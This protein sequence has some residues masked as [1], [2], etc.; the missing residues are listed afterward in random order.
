VNVERYLPVLVVHASAHE[1][2][3]K[4]LGEDGMR[5]RHG[6]AASARRVLM[7]GAGILAIAGVTSPSARAIDFEYG[8]V[9]GSLINTVS[10]GMQMRVSDRDRRLMGAAN[11]GDPVL[12]MTQNAEDNN[13]HFNQGDIVSAP[14]KLTTELNLAWRN[15]G[16][17]GRGTAFYDPIYDN[18]KLADFGDPTSPTFGR[19]TKAARDKAARGAEVQDLFV[20][21]EF[22]IGTQPLNVRIGQQTLNWGEALFTQNAISIINPLDLQKLVVP[23][24]ELRDGLI[25]VPMA[26]ASYEIVE[27]LAIEGFY[28]WEFKKLRLSPTGT[29]FGGSDVVEESNDGI[30]GVSNGAD[31]GAAGQN[32]PCAR[33]LANR[34]PGDSGNWGVKLNVFSEALN[35][36]EFGLYFVHYTSRF[37]SLGYVVTSGLPGAADVNGNPLPFN[38]NQ[39]YFTNVYSRT[40][41]AKGIKMVGLSFNT[42]WDEPG[43]AFNGELSYKMDE[44]GAIYGTTTYLQ[45]LCQGLGIASNGCGNQVGNYFGLPGAN[46]PGEI[47]GYIPL[48]AYHANLR[49][50]KI[51]FQ[52][53]PIVEATGAESLTLVNE[54]SLVYITNLPDSGRLSLSPQI[55][56][57]CGA[58]ASFGVEGSCR[59]RAATK[60]SSYTNFLFQ[61]SYPGAFGT[62]INLTPGLYYGMAIQ[63]NSPLAAGS[64]SGFRAM[65]L[66]LKAEYQQNLNVVLNFAKSWGGGFRNLSADKDFVGVTVN[67]AF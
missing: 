12:G 42:T 25:P 18:N 11:G 47:Q 49:M 31:C 30:G 3:Q 44:P 29:Y 28:Q 54:T 59:V 21:G 37:P 8:E 9:K 39:T 61:L 50:T 60:L 64:Q 6:R 16:F 23:G 35:N 27:G 34:D 65:N 55:T 56:N 58:G 43:I 46:E 36:T 62:P 20:R 19:I 15:L 13:K 51:L 10:A 5:E 66:S 32:V 63:G 14:L 24:S 26:W 52:A 41:Y 33:Q 67:Y 38:G 40:E 4:P 17:Y 57:G 53:N 2:G 48:N 7:L 22:D 45:A 1:S